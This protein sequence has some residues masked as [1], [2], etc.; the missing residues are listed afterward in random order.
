MP[1]NSI[2][3]NEE[4]IKA[5]LDGRKTQTRR[6]HAEPKYQVGDIVYVK[7]PWKIKQWYQDD[8]DLDI[9]YV[10]DGTVKHKSVPYEEDDS[11]EIFNEYWIESCDDYIEAGVPF[12]EEN[13]RYETPEINPC[14]LRPAEE[15]PEYFSRIQLKITA[16]RKEKLQDITEQDA[17]AEGFGLTP[18]D[19]VKEDK[20]PSITWFRGLWDSIYGND[21]SKQWQANPWVWVYEFERV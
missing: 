9:E 10:V 3:F 6:P 13:E 2:S 19:I 4:M 16:I 21:E 1:I 14:R 17:I 15:M 11:G 5:I 8:G 12:N 7:E 18:K 20:T